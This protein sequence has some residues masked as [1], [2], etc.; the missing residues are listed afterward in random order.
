MATISTTAIHLEERAWIPNNPRLPV[1][2]YDAA[3]P[4]EGGDD[5]ATAMEARFGANGWP[6]QWRNGIYDFHH[7][8]SQG[9]E[10]LGIAAGSAEVVLG[11]P[12]G[13]ILAVRA[14]N[15]LLLPAGT[16]HCRGNASSNF[17][18]VGAYPPG[19]SGNIIRDAPTSAIREAI[20]QLRFPPM[21]PVYGQDGPLTQHWANNL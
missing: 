6:A 21:D 10:V 19:Q 7:Y 18:V 11:G 12:K 20:A 14:G 16:G 1:I 15:V 5:L 17:L 8:H 9:H 13:R 3:F 2:V 4:G